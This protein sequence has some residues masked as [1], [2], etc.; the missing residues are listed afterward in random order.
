MNLDTTSTKQK[1]KNEGAA[2]EGIEPADQPHR[3]IHVQ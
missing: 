3:R 2:A 1:K